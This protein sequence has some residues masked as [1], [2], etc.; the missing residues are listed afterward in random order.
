MQIE[1][2]DGVGRPLRLGVLG[3]TFDPPHVGHLV[4]AGQVAGALD[5]DRVVFVVA[6]EPWQ[7]ADFS[8]AEDRLLMTALAAELHPKFAVSRIEIDRLGPTY[9]VDTLTAL[10]DFYGAGLELF[11]ILGADALKLLPTWHRTESLPDLA[12]FV[13][14][15]RPGVEFVVPDGTPEVAR[16]ES[17]ALDIS[18]TGIREL[19]RTGRPIDFL[20]PE[21]VRGYIAEHG[22]YQGTREQAHA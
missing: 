15:C 9:T 13:A 8:S 4:I 17:P 12:R 14:V 16:V 19:V 22:L 6:G 20:V 21:A 10:H 11:F 7:K 18:S 1:P 5:L 2:E 3:G